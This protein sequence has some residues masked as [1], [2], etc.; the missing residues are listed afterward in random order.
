M[1][2]EKPGRA[3]LPP[4]KSRAVV[5]PH[6]SNGIG[7]LLPKGRPDEFVVYAMPKG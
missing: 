1:V 7:C 4:Y 2:K 3:A 5:V 6:V